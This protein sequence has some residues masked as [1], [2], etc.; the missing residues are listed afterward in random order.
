MQHRR[1][2]WVSAAVAAVLVSCAAGSG[3]NTIPFSAPPAERG[4]DASVA[5]AAGPQQGGGLR[6]VAATPGVLRPRTE[7]VWFIETPGS[8]PSGG[9]ATVGPDGSLDLGPYGQFPVAGLTADQARARIERQLGR[10]Y[11]NPKVQLRLSEVTPAAD[12]GSS[13]PAPQQQPARQAPAQAVKS[14]WRPVQRENA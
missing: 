6:T 13:T 5:R 2:G 4:N 3:C 10:Q 11:R 7:V 8:P 1:T 9:P 12:W 14:V